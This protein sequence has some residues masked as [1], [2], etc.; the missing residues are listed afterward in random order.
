LHFQRVNPSGPRRTPAVAPR[1]CRA[2]VP[3]RRLR[4]KRWPIWGLRCSP[5]NH[6]TRGRAD[7]NITY[8]LSHALYCADRQNAPLCSRR[9]PH[10]QDPHHRWRHGPFIADRYVDAR[11]VPG[12]RNSMEPRERPAGEFHRRAAR[13]EVDH[14]H[15]APKHSGAQT[16]A[17]RLGARLLG[18][19]TLRI[20]LR[21]SHAAIGFC[22]FGRR[23]DTSE[24][25][26]AVP[27]DGALDAA[28]IDEIGADAENHARPRSIAARIV[29]T[30]SARPR[31]TASPTKK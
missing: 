25:T 8:A 29:L 17:E 10:G 4:R 6:D 22:P 2:L 11:L 12:R 19:E 3:A 23:E 26:L 24:E 14:P 28:D 16:G 9:D 20:G 5:G 27:L 1:L 21:L 15:V 30:A 7:R 13:G 31:D 18:G